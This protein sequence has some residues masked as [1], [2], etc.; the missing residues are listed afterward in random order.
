[1]QHGERTDL[2]SRHDVQKS[3]T[4]ILKESDIEPR[5]ANR[6][7]TPLTTVKMIWREKP[8]LLRDVDV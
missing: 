7:S 1:M 3:K 5:Q 2:A 4:E 8:E 6:P